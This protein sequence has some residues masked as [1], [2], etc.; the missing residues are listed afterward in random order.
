MEINRYCSRKYVDTT[1]KRFIAACDHFFEQKKLQSSSQNQEE[2]KNLEAKKAVIE[3]IEHLDV[4]LSSDEALPLLREWM[5]EWYQIGYVP[6][7]AKDKIYKEFYAATEAQ[8]DR[9]NIDKAERKLESFKTNLSD[10]AKS[11]NAK[12]QLLREREKLMRQYDRMKNELQTYENNIGFLSVSSKKGNSLVDDMNQ[13]VK[14]IKT[15][16]EFIVKKIEAIDTEL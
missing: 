13:K 6:Y 8:F 9:L 2:V 12:G 15:D 3:K 11:E 1:W 4:S 5:D 10:M 16:I 7:K 14:K